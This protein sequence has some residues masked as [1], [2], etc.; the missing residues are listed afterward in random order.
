[1][2]V[3]ELLTMPSLNG[4]LHFLEDSTMTPNCNGIVPDE[5]IEAHLAGHGIP[6]LLNK[7]GWVDIPPIGAQ[8]NWDATCFDFVLTSRGKCF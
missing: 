7:E 5:R 6:L 1:M 3:I 4:I 2:Q 8:A